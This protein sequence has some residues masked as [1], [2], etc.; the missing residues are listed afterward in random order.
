[1]VTQPSLF[2]SH[3][4]PDMALK[5]SPARRFLTGLGGRIE[6]PDAIVIASA[7]NEA[8]RPTV[9]SPARF[10]TWH[11]F[12]NFDP[13]LFEMRYEP[14]GAPALASDVEAR[15]QQA[16]FDAVQVSDRRLDHGA[17]VPLSLLFPAA[18]VP[19]VA[20]S[21]DPAKDS[22]WHARLGAALE[23]LRRRNILVIGSGSISH[24]LHEVFRP[25][26][27]DRQW[28]E[29]FTGWLADAAVRGDREAL[30]GAMEAAPEA[31]RNHPTDEHLLPFFFAMGAGGEG[32]TAA[33]L[34]HSYTWDVL[35]MDVYAFGEAELVARLAA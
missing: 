4:A 33:R 16:G 30:L 18:D 28:V 24:N 14:A 12:G 9:R 21:I 1:M 32:E 11:D 29:A 15:L 10:S 8:S 6:R 20:V 13:R 26:G 31:T 35:A 34:H 23:P 5:E 19:L 22:R 27:E 7:H 3:G 2:L 17:W 25:T